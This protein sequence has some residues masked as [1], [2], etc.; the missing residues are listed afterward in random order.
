MLGEKV[1]ESGPWYGRLALRT[2]GSFIL[3]LA[4][5][6]W[7]RPA[8]LPLL[9]EC[10][11]KAGFWGPL[12]YIFFYTIRPLAALPALPFNLSAP[13]FFG[14]LLGAACI[15][16]GG[17]GGALVCF[18]GARLLGTKFAGKVASYPLMVRWQRQLNE[19]GF[20]TVL[21]LR[22]TPIFPYDPVSIALGLST[23]PTRAYIYGTFL[24][25]LPGAVAYGFSGSLLP[26]N[27]NTWEYIFITLGVVLAF[28]APMW[29]YRHRLHTAGMD[30]WLHY[31]RRSKKQ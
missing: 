17:M 14:P 29:I 6:L 1:N 19:K 2:G 3:L 7:W 10:V 23:V 31:W 18:W 5:F 24:G 13:L 9:Q 26:G 27:L 15:V 20:G 22:L 30:G 8:I 11:A 21:F 4:C 12:V 25:M 16:I 28:G